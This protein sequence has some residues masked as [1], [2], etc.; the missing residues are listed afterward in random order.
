[1]KANAREAFLNTIGETPKVSM[2]EYLASLRQYGHK[3]LQLGEVT[4]GKTV[5]AAPRSQAW[6]R[7]CGTIIMGC[8]PIMVRG[9]A[10]RSAAR[11]RLPAEH[12]RDVPMLAHQQFCRR[13]WV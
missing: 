13:R 11:S 12:R 3:P 2:L 4:I 7:A 8:K 1:M 5:Y 10:E 6:A 9:G